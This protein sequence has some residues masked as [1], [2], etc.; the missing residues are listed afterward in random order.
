[1]RTLGV[2]AREKAL[3]DHMFSV[4]YTYIGPIVMTPLEAHNKRVL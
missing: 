1:M 2:R 3:N 4:K